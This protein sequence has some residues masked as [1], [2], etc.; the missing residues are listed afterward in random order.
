MHHYR[1]IPTARVRAPSPIPSNLT[2]SQWLAALSLGATAFIMVTIELLPIGL[3]PTIAADIDVTHGAA[4]LLVTMSGVMAAVG[5][6]TISVLEGGETAKLCS[7]RCPS[8]WLFPVSL[9]PPRRRS[10]CSWWRGSY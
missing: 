3:L 2:T 8:S 6:P 9:L 7:W 1:P 5:A 4:G 10:S